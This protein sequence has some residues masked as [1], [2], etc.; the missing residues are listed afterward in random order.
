MNTT[1]FLKVIAIV[2]MVLGVASIVSWFTRK[3]YMGL[4]DKFSQMDAQLNEIYNNGVAIGW[5]AAKLQIVQTKTVS[6]DKVI[7]L[8]TIPDKYLLKD[9]R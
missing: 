9:E 6:I 8:D 4:D 2:L 1:D 3:L 5:E 7:L